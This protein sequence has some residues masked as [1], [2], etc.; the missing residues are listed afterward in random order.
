MAQKT[1]RLDRSDI[2]ITLLTALYSCVGHQW[3]NCTPTGKSSSAPT[4]RE[5]GISRP[6]QLDIQTRLSGLTAVLGR[7]YSCLVHQRRTTF[8]PVNL[9]LHPPTTFRETGISR[10]LQLDMQSRLSG[11]TAVLGRLYSCLVH[12]RRT[13]FKPVNLVPH[14]PSAQAGQARRPRLRLVKARRVGDH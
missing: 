10:P 13:T 3:R 7:L 1:D 12:Q 8:K 5:T 4:F 2:T 11:L 14:P 9:V 6:L